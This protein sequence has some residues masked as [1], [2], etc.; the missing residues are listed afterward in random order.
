MGE[1]VMDINGV[2]IKRGDK[3]YYATTD[4]YLKLLTVNSITD[5]HV[6]MGRCSCRHYNTKFQIAVI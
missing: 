3:V 2:P 1:K 5:T 6:K 4:G